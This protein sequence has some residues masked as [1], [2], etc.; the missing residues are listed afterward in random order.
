MSGSGDKNRVARRLSRRTLLAALAAGSVGIADLALP[1]QFARAVGS[2]ARPLAPSGAGNGW[3]EVGDQVFQALSVSRSEL[4]SFAQQLTGYVVLPGTP[5]YDRARQG[6]GLSPYS[7]HPQ[8]LVYCRAVQDV[9]LCLNLAQR[10]QW[11]ITCR[12]GGHSTAGFSVNNGMVIDV[13][14][15]S[16]V[17]VDPVLKQAT[18]GSGTRFDRLNAVLDGYQLHVPGGACSDVGTAGYM[19]GGGYG[20]TSREFGIHSDNVLSAKL[21]LADG[22]IVVASRSVN[23]DLYWAIRGGTG[24][25]FGVLLETTYQLYDLHDVWGFCLQWPLADAPAALLELQNAYTKSGAPPQLGHLTALTFVDDQP[26]AAFTGMYHGAREDGLTAISSLLSTGNPTLTIDQIGSYAGLNDSLLD[27]LT[28]EHPPPGRIFEAKDCGYIQAGLRLS[29]WQAVVSYFAT[30]PNPY[31][32]VLLEPY[33][34][35]IND[36]PVEQSAFIHRDV[37]MDLYIDTFWQEGTDFTDEAAA[38]TWLAGYSDLMSAYWSDHKYQNYPQRGFADFRWAYWGDAFNS[39]LF[40]KQKYDPQNFFHYEQSISPYPDDP[41][42]HCSSAPSLF[43]DP[44][45]VYQSRD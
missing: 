19:Q 20:Y 15:L 28:I 14:G 35:A 34:G 1:A 40:V 37:Y 33:G 16:D 8:I 27:I 25:N 43:N 18:V 10:Q 2:V 4:A 29:D 26:V 36:Y 3:P 21:M 9:R 41:N 23:P 24:G 5:P 31:N 22:S 11:W 13:T 32:L 6:D 44:A 39:L 38:R 30:T 42:I 12:S 7:E 45:I 17:T